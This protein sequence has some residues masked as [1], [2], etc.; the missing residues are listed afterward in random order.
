[1]GIGEENDC[2]ARCDIRVLVDKLSTVIHFVVDDE[3]EVILAGVLG[4]V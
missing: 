2:R 3:V 1:M 4:N